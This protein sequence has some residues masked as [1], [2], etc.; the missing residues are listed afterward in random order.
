MDE[1]DVENVEPETTAGFVD[2]RS[3]RFAAL[4]AAGDL[5][6]EQDFITIDATAADALTN[7]RLIVVLGGGVDEAIA[8]FQRGGH[9]ICAA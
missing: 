5:R 8:G 4:A 7:R 9:G 3:G 6:S 2:A 1:D